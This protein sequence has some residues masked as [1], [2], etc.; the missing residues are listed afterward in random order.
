MCTATASPE[1]RGAGGAGPP[2]STMV[3]SLWRRPAEERSKPQ[4]GSPGGTLLGSLRARPRGRRDQ[5]PSAGRTQNGSVSRPACRRRRP[6]PAGHRGRGRRPA[7]VPGT[8]PDR[9]YR[10]MAPPASPLR[11]PGRAA[12]PRL[13]RAGARPRPAGA[14]RTRLPCHP[15][16]CATRPAPRARRESRQWRRRGSRPS[17]PAPSRGQRQRGRAPRAHEPFGRPGRSMACLAGRGG[18]P[19]IPR[20]GSGLRCDRSLV[21]RS[22][23]PASPP[24]PRAALPSAAR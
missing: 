14:P 24:P 16:P 10:S 3:G 4:L 6:G 23:A 5:L 2:R 9:R 8:C 18:A 12:S 1:T 17:A 21:P 11:E 20:R 22:R 15:G 19:G 7:C 13:P